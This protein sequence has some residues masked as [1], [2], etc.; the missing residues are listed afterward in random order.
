[1]LGGEL[2]I[3]LSRASERQSRAVSSGF[4]RYDE[5]SPRDTETRLVGV[6]VCLRDAPGRIRTSDQRLR[7]PSLFH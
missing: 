6:S 1:M 3:P 2:P 5:A 4:K 7:R